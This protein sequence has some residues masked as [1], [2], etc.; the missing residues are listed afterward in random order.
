MRSI[1]IAATELSRTSPHARG[2]AGQTRHPTSAAFADL[3]ND[4]DLDL[5]VCH[6]MVWDPENPRL[7]R[8]NNGDSIY[9]D[10]RRVTAAPDHVFRNDGGRFVDVTATA[11][12]AEI[13][14]RGLGRRRGRLR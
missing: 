2:L 13:Q 5:Y 14:G 10:P 1:T 12:I 11:G 3:D 7:C 9:C 6:Y 8:N 4:G